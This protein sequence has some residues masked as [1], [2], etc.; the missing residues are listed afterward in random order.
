MTSESYKDPS[1]VVAIVAA[2]IALVAMAV[3][4][5]SCVLAFIQAKASKA[6]ANAAEQQAHAATE[7]TR[8]IRQQV[9]LEK[10]VALSAELTAADTRWRDTEKLFLALRE[11][12]RA[13]SKGIHHKAPQSNPLFG[14]DSALDQTAYDSFTKQV[15]EMPMEWRYD[16]RS[17]VFKHCAMHIEGMMNS[18]FRAEQVSK[19]LN[20]LDTFKTEKLTALKAEKDRLEEERDSLKGQNQ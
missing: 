14:Y 9:K 12:V 3:S 2:V 16:I 20:D 1:V 15:D 19:A 13:L 7:Q 11:S 8:Q 18:K 5:A 4:I 10:E 17:L 6:S